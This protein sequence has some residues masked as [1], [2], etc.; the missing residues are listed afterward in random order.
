M[1]IKRKN[2]IFIYICLIFF[3]GITVSAA[4]KESFAKIS[5]CHINKKTVKQGDT[6]KYSFQIKTNNMKKNSRLSSVDYVVVRW[7]SASGQYIDVKQEWNRKKYG[8]FPSVIPI[9]GK[10]KIRK[11][12]EK[13]KWKLRFVAYVMDAGE[14]SE[15]QKIFNKKTMYNGEKLTSGNIAQDLSCFN[16]KVK[17]KA[18]A[19]WEAPVLDMDSLL[20]EEKD[21]EGH[22]KFSLKVQDASPI[23]YVTCF[24]HATEMGEVF[25]RLEIL[26]KYNKKK[27]RYE[28]SI[29]NLMG[30]GNTYTKLTRIRI[31]DI[32]GNE[33]TYSCQHLNEANTV[34]SDFS[35]MV[36]YGSEEMKTYM[37]EHPEKWI[38]W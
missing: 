37:E 38:E 9:S 32:Y 35:Q 13:G 21:K 15:Y 29:S 18:K 33:V 16:F 28:A 5:D 20:L 10:I 8:K 14:D 3:S 26:M 2:I 12:M 36:I 22:Y 7:E 24:W 25:D 27:K 4:K 30:S 31:C 11:G 1:K 23:K 19:D 6:F 17:K 34:Q